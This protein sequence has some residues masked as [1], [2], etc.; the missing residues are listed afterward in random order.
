MSLE[1]MP[2]MSVPAALYCAAWKPEPNRPCS[3]PATIVNTM[4]ASGARFDSTRAS[5]IT[6]ATPDASSPAAGCSMSKLSTS[7][8]RESMC[9]DTT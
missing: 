6:T 8:A 4:V 7:V 3:S 5:S 9:P 2:W 1:N